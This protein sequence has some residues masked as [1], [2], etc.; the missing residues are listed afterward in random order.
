MQN[1]ILEKGIHMLDTKAATGTVATALSAYAGWVDLA[2]PI[3]SLAV[4]VIVGGLT[5][6]YTWE[7][8]V[9]LRDERKNR[10]NK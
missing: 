8:A 10:R 6:W 5:A 4:T 7:R 2:G 9:K 3:A 1:A